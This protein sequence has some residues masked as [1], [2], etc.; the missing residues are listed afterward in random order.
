MY[1]DLALYIDGKWVGGNGRKGEEVLNPA[2]EKPLAHL[3][4]ASKADLDEALAAAKKGFAL[5]RATSA[6]DRAKIMRKAADL[7][8][9]RHDAI[10]KILVQE[11][12]KVYVEA[13][14]EVITSA[15][16]IDWYAEEGRRSYG[17]IVPG[18]AKGTRQLVVTEPVGIVAAFTPWNFPV[19][20]PARKIG[21]A[22]AAGCA[23]IL[24]ASEETP[25]AC[26]EVVRCFA[27]AGLPNGVLNLLFG[28]PAEVSEYLLAKDAVRKISFT[29]SIPVGKHL[30]ALAAK[31]MKRT[32][33]A[34]GGHSP[35]GGFAGADPEKAADTIAAFKYRNAGQVCISPTRF[36]VQE[37]V[38]SRFLKR[39][40][41]YANGIKIGDGLEKG[42]TMG[43]MANARRIEAMEGFVNDAKSRGGK[44]QTG[45][46]RHGNQGFFYEP[47]VITD[48]PDDAKVMKNEPFGQ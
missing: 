24:K 25:G 45:G 31:G 21:G 26:V 37:D 17:R 6:Y 23:L 10:S 13:R 16:I 3:P 46:K 32:P 27:D 11:Q 40:T 48:I 38:Y 41:E 15:D 20:T 1:T 5:W 28:V 22:L 30:A 42:I 18:R 4:H 47:T 36:Y 2:T 14:G 34:V 9:E 29:G 35:V 7:I 43:P 19:L 33:M 12:G 8:R 44:I 39:F